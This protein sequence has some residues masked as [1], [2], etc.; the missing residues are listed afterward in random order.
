MFREANQCIAF[1]SYTNSPLTTAPEKMCARAF[2]RYCRDDAAESNFNNDPRSM[3]GVIRSL[4][5][6]LGMD[7]NSPSI[8]QAKSTIHTGRCSP[9]TLLP[10][11][12]YRYGIVACHIGHFPYI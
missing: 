12:M 11:I 3:K 1:F 8:V 9:P 2:K 10:T 7:N 4:T 5:T 6:S